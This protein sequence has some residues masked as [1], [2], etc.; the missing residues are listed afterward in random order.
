MLLKHLET[1]AAK[2]V[3]FPLHQGCLSKWYSST[4]QTIHNLLCAAPSTLGV[5]H[6]QNLCMMDYSPILHKGQHKLTN[7]FTLAFHTFTT[8]A[9]FQMAHMKLASFLLH[10]LFQML[11]HRYQGRTTH[12]GSLKVGFVRL[13]YKSAPLFMVFK[14]QMNPSSWRIYGTK[15]W[16]K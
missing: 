3:L 16:Q 7:L 6:S 2:N 13:F 11:D 1:L 9:L 8:I 10:H 14:K 4:H 15:S 5:L 12:H